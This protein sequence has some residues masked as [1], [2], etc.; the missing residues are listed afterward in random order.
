MATAAAPALSGVNVLDLSHGV[1]GGYCT[2]VLAD[3]GAQVI[4]V[5]P[6]SV[7]DA[8][9]R[10]GPFLH[11][12]PN[13]EA[14]APF[15]YLHMGKKGVTLN[16]KS[17]TGRSILLR[18]VQQTDV[19]VENFRPGVMARLGLDYASLEQVNPGLIMASISYFGQSGPYRDYEG[20]DM[21]A[22]AISG[23]MYLTGDEDREPLRA[24]GCQSGYQAGLQAAMAILAALTYR[25]FTTEGQHIDVS[26]IEA[27][28]STFDGVAVYTMLERQGIMPR[29]AGTRLINRDPYYAYPST[30]LPCK[31]G[32]VHVHYSPSNPEGLAFLAGNPR[33]AAPEV[34]AAMMG[35]ADEMDRILS[36]W[37]KDHTR[38]EIQTAAQEIRVPFTMVQS[39]AEV[40]ED[41]QNEAMGF[42]VEIDHPVAGKLRYPSSPFHMPESPW[43]PVRAPL[44]GEHNQEIYCQRLGYS[45]ED[46]VRLRE[47]NII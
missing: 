40:V 34:M 5:E 20:C 30:L 2:K 7:G 19:L 9:R 42:F 4:K 12:V 8:T 1:S 25:D 10:A 26:T 41:P 45:R 38:E 39:I 24:G 22:H 16:L 31:D 21:V 18:L 32:W 36:E 44:L 37:L 47:M 3:L 27:L 23:Y 46:L 17:E 28:A 43:K 14:S 29:R 15:L 6:P 33:L 13:L 11:D 35:H